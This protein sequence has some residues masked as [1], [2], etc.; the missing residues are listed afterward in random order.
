MVLHS[1]VVTASVNL[2]THP[3][4]SPHPRKNLP[5]SLLLE[6]MRFGHLRMKNQLAGFEPEDSVLPLDRHK[7]QHC[8]CVS[9]IE[10]CEN[11]FIILLM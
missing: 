10:A 11:I 8:N 9:L 4:D 7:K 6:D 5:T 3:G 1:S 2:S